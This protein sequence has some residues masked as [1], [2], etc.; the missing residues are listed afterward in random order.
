[1]TPGPDR[2]KTDAMDTRFLIIGGGIAG[3]SAGYFLAKHGETVL[4][5]RESQPGYHSTGRSAALF[6]E[7]YGNPVVRSLALASRPFL[8]APPQGFTDVPLMTPRGTLFLARTDQLETLEE[9]L[10]EAQRLCP[11]IHKVSAERAVEL[12]PSVDPAYPAAAMFEPDSMDLD[13]DAIHQGFLRGFRRAGGDVRMDAEVIAIARTGGKW[14]VETRAGAFTAEILINAAGAWCDVIAEMA[15]IAPVG[16]TP[17]RRTAMT[18]DPPDGQDPSGWASIID[19]DEEFYWKPDAGKLLGSPA[20][21]TPVPPQ[22]IQPEELDIAIAVDRI[23]TASTMEI[24]RIDH[25]WAGLRSFVG[26]K[27]PVVGAD[28]A[29]PSFIWCAGQGGYGIM[30]S[31]AM[32]QATAAAAAGTPFPAE[33]ESAGVSAADLQPDRLR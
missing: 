28:P 8:D 24:K 5:E 4:L 20:D 13:V 6:T 19:I 2:P 32:G 15:G 25:T 23:Q 16:L 29:E 33:I 7:Y 14:Q 31:P 12:C 30:T 26:D 1:M 27:T 18:F 17:K 21:E 10:P 22:D 3:A 11:N 9:I